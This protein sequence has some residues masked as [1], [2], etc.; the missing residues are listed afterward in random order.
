[1][2]ILCDEESSV[3]PTANSL[4]QINHERR[5]YRN[6]YGAG[7]INI[8]HLFNLTVDSENL[9]NLSCESSMNPPC[10]SSL[11]QLSQKN[12]PALLT[13]IVI[14]LTIA[15][16][17]LVIMAVSLEKKLQNATNY[18][19]MSLAIAD[20]LLGFLVM[21]VSMLT[22]L[23]GYT[24][25]LPT[26]LCA[27]WIYLDVLFSTA[28]IMHLCAIS[29]DRYIAIRN[30]IHHSRFNSRTKA[31]AKIIAVW[32]I[33]VGISMPIPVFGLQDD[34]KVFKKES[35]LLA[36]DNFVLVGS[37]VAFFI[38]L[39]IM[40]VTYFLTIRSLQKE[41][42]LCVNDI[43]PKTKF[44]SFSF[45]P[46]SSLSSEKLFQRSLNR[47]V[48][49]AGRRTMQS[50]SNEQKASKV[51]GIV[52]FLF[53]VMW[54][55]FFITNVMAVICKESCNEEV[56]GGLLNVFV[57]IGYLSSAVNP[58]VYTLF[59]K[60]Y[61]S[62]FSRYIQ[63]RYKEE[64]K[65]FQ[66]ILVNTIPA[67]AYNS[68]QLQLAQMKSL[69]KEAKM[70]AKDYSMVTIGIHHLD[71]TS[72]GSISPVNEKGAE[73]ACKLYDG[74]GTLRFSEAQF[75]P[76]FLRVQLLVCAV[77][78]TCL[79]LTNCF[80]V[81]ITHYKSMNV[82]LSNLTGSFFLA[83]KAMA[84]KQVSSNKC[85]EGFQKVFEHDSAELKCKM[86]FGIYLPP[87]AETAK[88]PVLYWLSGLTCT[89]QN[90]ITKAGFH[91]AAAEHGLIVVAPDT[92]PRGCNIEG[93]DESWDFGTGAGF[94]VDATE[95][96]WKTNYRMYS[97]IKDE[98]P[99]L[100][101]ANFP[102][103]PER[104]SVFG[105]SMGGHG[106][107]ILALKNPGKYKAYDATQLVKSYPDSH[108]DILIDQGKDDQFLSAGQLLPDNFIAACTE[109]KI[110]VVFRLQQASCFCDPSLLGC[111]FVIFGSVCGRQ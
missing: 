81:L 89:E 8:S 20:M 41:A 46:Q 83:D 9:T 55:P 87:K 51:L 105:H 43:G 67:L 48:G 18:F 92:S 54:C 27:I 63:C 73:P 50:I 76:K 6:V 36:D 84:L 106:A 111:C 70:M 28:S 10:Y 79:H 25:P 12:W 93:E 40:V 17:I 72:K 11:I 34:R 47:D 39:T 35:C 109:R 110:P 82:L 108:L 59:N 45:L 26:K 7:E 1:M 24:W 15:G 68:S 37:F 42:T 107:L 86:K 23:Y 52:F 69:K 49:T 13:V 74:H 85:F 58:L 57:W 16:N 22:I 30:P 4:M 5:L 75:L 101:N 103:D 64:K 19:L 56:I 29:L 3:N 21:P 60:T 77:S 102:T 53:V 32:T 100:I 38:P 95:D 90:F 80:S 104:M 78:F 97:Y 99:K 98:L 2:D 61:R 65:P 44:A 91:Q 94:Y 62:A 14:V 88:C 96:P 33:S 66:L 31:F 71:G